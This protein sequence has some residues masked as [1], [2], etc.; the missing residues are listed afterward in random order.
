MLEENPPVEIQYTA[1]P[2]YFQLFTEFELWFGH[3]HLYINCPNIRLFTE[4]AADNRSA[5]A[6]FTRDGGVAR[7]L[8]A[9]LIAD[10]R[11]IGGWE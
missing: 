5:C 10:R 8:H 1:Y 4:C 11:S 7:R 6:T 3:C 2:A 9:P